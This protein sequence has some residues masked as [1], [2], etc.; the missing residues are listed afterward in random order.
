MAT[1]ALPHAAQRIFT[2]I[3]ARLLAVDSREL[4]NDLFNIINFHSS[5]NVEPTI[6][7][8]ERESLLVPVMDQ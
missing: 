5:E 7:A 1:E 3:I 6:G 2:I 4:I 8:H